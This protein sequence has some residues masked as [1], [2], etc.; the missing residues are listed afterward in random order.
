MQIDEN[1][2]VV[3]QNADS[4][5]PLIVTTSPSIVANPVLGEVRFASS[6]NQYSVKIEWEG[7][8]YEWFV[9]RVRCKVM[10]Y[11]DTSSMWCYQ[12]NTLG[13][14]VKKTIKKKM[15]RI[16]EEAVKNLA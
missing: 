8:L 13:V 2:F 1:G 11:T 7:E 4:S 6:R 16:V 9:D 3:G 5:G 15:R 10:H 12:I 14:K